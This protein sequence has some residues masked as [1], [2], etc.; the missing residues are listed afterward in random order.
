[1]SDVGFPGSEEAEQRDARFD[2]LG[3]V[4]AA[5]QI[6]KTRVLE[7]DFGFSESKF[8]DI[9]SAQSVKILRTRLECSRLNRRVKVLKRPTIPFPVYQSRNVRFGY[10]T[11][12]SLPWLKYSV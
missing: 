10:F 11:V 2:K 12:C 1:M 5:G 9:E 8:I 7:L 6:I 3:A 4:R